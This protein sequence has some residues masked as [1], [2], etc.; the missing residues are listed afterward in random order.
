MECKQPLNIWW[1]TKQ[2]RSLLVDITDAQRIQKYQEI[3][4]SMQNICPTNPHDITFD[5]T[6]FFTNSETTNRLIRSEWLP[7]ILTGK[8]S[9]FFNKFLQD[10]R[11]E[12]QLQSISIDQSDAFGDRFQQSEKKK[13]DIAKEFLQG[14]F[15]SFSLHH[16]TV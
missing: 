16:R 12:K 4:K 8:D 2:N 3:K 9:N 11:L 14:K 15:G 13:L 10:L 1:T 5:W 7:A 6:Y